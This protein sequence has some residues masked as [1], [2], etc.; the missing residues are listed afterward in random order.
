MIKTSPFVN[1]FEKKPENTVIEYVKNG[2]IY[3]KVVKN[4]V[5]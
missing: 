1:P 5:E 4:A 3:R 2:I